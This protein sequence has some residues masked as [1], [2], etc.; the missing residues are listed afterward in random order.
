M[1]EEKVTNSIDNYGNEQQTDVDDIS[2]RYLTFELSALIDSS[3]VFGIALKDV[4]EIVSLETP[5]EVP[6]APSY[7]K[8]IINL[9]GSV[10]PLV[11][12]NERFGFPETEYDER[13]CI[14][15][16]EINENRIG[17]IVNKVFEVVTIKKISPLP[18]E[19]D[20][21]SNKYVSGIAN[22]D[23]GKAVLIMDTSLVIDAGALAMV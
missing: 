20:K 10:V 9:R 15:V 21:I 5:A 3:K 16:A 23:S 12:I 22:M 4:I 2:N 13:S 18:K 14:I 1:D 6:Y 17:L 11:D 19:V 7:V 8:G